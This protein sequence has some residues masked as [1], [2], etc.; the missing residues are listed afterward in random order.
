VMAVEDLDIIDMEVPFKNDKV[1]FVIIDGLSWEND[2][3]IS[4]HLTTLMRKVNFYLDVA[5]SDAFRQ[6]YPKTSLDKF[7]IETIFRYSPPDGVTN[8][9]DQTVLKLKGEGVMF[10]YRV[11]GA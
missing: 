3:V 1:L 6:K 2:A 8:F 10:T 7:G 5:G 4:H 9:L 11:Y